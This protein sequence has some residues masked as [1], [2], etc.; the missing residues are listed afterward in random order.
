MHILFVS[1]SDDDKRSFQCYHLLSYGTYWSN[2]TNYFVLLL[3]SSNSVT[4]STLQTPECSFMPRIL[5]AESAILRSS[6]HCL[7]VECTVHG[8]EQEWICT[9]SRAYW[10][11]RSTPVRIINT[12]HPL[13]LFFF[14]FFFCSS[15]LYCWVFWTELNTNSFQHFFKF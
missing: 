4:C 5:Q 1:W 6:F 3:W 15:L 8:A 2:C 11:S 9:A 7:H 10:Y 12:A 13:P 14:F